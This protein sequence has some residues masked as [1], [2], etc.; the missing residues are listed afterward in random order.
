VSGVLAALPDPGLP[1]ES[2][3]AALRAHAWVQDAQFGEG[4]LPGGQLTILL[5]PSAAGI[6]ELR[7]H[8]KRRVVEVLE[9]YLRPPA[10]TP[11][12][13]WRLVESCEAPG[14]PAAKGA[15]GPA[16]MPLVREL[17]VAADSRSLSCQLRVPFELPVFGGHFPSR[18]IVPGVMQLG[19]ASE[20]ARSHGLV[21][22]RVSGISTAKFRRL[23]LPG[24]C[25]AARIERGPQEG[26]LQFT[27]R[28]G[29]GVVTT[30]RLRFEDSDD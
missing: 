15:S 9:Q 30:G 23:V 3:V 14:D 5:V 16:W 13:E 20:L 26:D 7:C 19:W 4:P 18:P 11:R 10:G 24:M 27:Y 29:H 25:L 28:L 17:A 8:G 6:R 21:T 1:F 12:A 2:I 22:G